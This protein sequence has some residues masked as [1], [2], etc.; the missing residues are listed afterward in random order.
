MPRFENIRSERCPNLGEGGCGNDLHL[1]EAEL[2][3][4]IGSIGAAIS[5]RGTV[6][7][8]V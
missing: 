4:A 1:Q 7:A 2:G 8:A 3:C 6:S 5:G